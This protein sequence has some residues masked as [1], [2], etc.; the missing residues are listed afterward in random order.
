MNNKLYNPFFHFDHF[1]IDISYKSHN[2]MPDIVPHMLMAA[3]NPCMG[4]VAAPAVA[5]VVVRIAG[6]ED[7]VA[8]AAVAVEV[9]GVVVSAA[10][11]DIQLVA[12]VV[13]DIVRTAAVTAVYHL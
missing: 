2:T 3:G 8:V 12:F 1:L 10:E 4:I 11:V 7:T 5:I 9:V 6:E 13:G